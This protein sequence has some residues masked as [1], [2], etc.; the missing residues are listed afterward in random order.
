MYTLGAETDL[1]VIEAKGLRYHGSSWLLSYLVHKGIIKARA[2]DKVEALKAGALVMSLEN[3]VPASE[4]TYAIKVAIDGALKARE[5]GEDKV[6]VAEISGAG[7]LDLEA[8][9]RKL[10]L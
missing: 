7:F 3:F 1:P 4:S 2:I 9:G 6:I 5:N 8:W 10:E